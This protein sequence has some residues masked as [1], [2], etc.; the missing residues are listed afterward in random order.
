MT[1]IVIMPIDP[2]SSYAHVTV[3]QI[4]PNV[5]RFI[6]CTQESIISQTE[7]CGQSCGAY[8]LLVSGNSRILTGLILSVRHSAR[9]NVNILYY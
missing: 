4:Y 5:S 2:V 8:T 3:V 7:C 9:H 1:L 6:S